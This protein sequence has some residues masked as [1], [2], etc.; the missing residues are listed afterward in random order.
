M[1]APD[2]LLAPDDDGATPLDPDECEGLIPA[3]VATRGDL[4]LV[5]Q[6]NVQAGLAWAKRTRFR[7]DVLSDDFLFGLHREMFGSVWRWAGSVR[8]SERN[9]GVAPHDIRPNLRQLQD[10]V[11]AW[12]AFDTYPRPECAARFHHRLVQIHVFP[13]GNGR[14]AR[15]ATDALLRQWRLPPFAWGTGLEPAD[16]RAAYLAALRAADAH[17]CRVLLRF[18]QSSHPRGS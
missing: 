18:L 2:D 15:E 1:P 9:I 5:E 11:R 17:D 14:H 8:K 13:N 12:V 16:A 10:D 4:N 3:W 7:G 6:A